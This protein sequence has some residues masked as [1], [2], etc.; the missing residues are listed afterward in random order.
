M[1]DTPSR[2]YAPDRQRFED[3]LGILQELTI[4][5]RILD[6]TRWTNLSVAECKKYATIEE[7]RGSVLLVTGNQSLRRS[8]SSAAGSEHIHDEVLNGAN[9]STV[10]QYA[11][12]PGNTASVLN[13]F[14]YA[15]KSGLHISYCLSLA[16]QNHCSLQIHLWLLLSVVVCNIIKLAC[17]IL[18][19]KEQQGT[20]LVTV[21]DAVASFLNLPCPNVKG[22]CLLSEDALI[23]ALK[24]DT[25]DTRDNI[26]PQ[27]R[28]YK[29]TSSR[30][31][32]SISFVRWTIYATS[33]V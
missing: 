15:R 4:K 16:V 10:F 3:R 1:F 13:E 11:I 31:Y 8:D 27:A 6:R 33:Y 25:E 20:P 28:R 9:S 23:S 18:T 32:Q 7:D 2:H 5:G 26:G 22:M 29:P 12:F 24:D 30:C 21:G 19:F 17:F 14:S